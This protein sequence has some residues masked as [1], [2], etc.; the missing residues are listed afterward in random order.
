MSASESYWHQLLGMFK[1]TKRL[2]FSLT[3]C[4]SS[5]QAVRKLAPVLFETSSKLAS[6]WMKIL[7]LQHVEVAEIEITDWV[8]RFA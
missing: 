8:G 7:D 4:Q 5:S 2:E 3:F 1:V 6:Q